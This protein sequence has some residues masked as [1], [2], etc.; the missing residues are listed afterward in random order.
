MKRLLLL[1][2]FTGAFVV[3]GHSQQLDFT[4]KM[5]SVLVMGNVSLTITV[6]VIGGS[7]DF[8]AFIYDGFPGKDGNIIATGEKISER[9]FK[10]SDVTLHNYYIGVLDKNQKFTC[11]SKVQIKPLQ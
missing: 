7:P 2:F 5:D 1:I 6:E 8:K 3:K 11:K 10:F 4:C 9:R